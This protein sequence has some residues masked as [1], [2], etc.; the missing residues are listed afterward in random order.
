MRYFTIDLPYN[1]VVLLKLILCQRNFCSPVYIAGIFL[2]GVE[3]G[4]IQLRFRGRV[5]SAQ[6]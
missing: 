2:Q 1:F 4:E 5:G 6:I 3:G